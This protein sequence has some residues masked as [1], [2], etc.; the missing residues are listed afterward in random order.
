V[1]T[2]PV[3]LAAR[4]TY[5]EPVLSRRL[6]T[7]LAAAVCA[8]ALAGVAR[9]D[10]DPAS[11]VLYTQRIFL[12]FFGPKIAPARAT[13]LKDLVDKAW[14]K[15]YKIKVALIAAPAD[16]GGIPQLYGKPKTYV[17]FL[18]QELVF[19]FKGPLVVAMPNGLGFYQ[20]KKPVSKEYAIISKIPVGSGTDGLAQAATTAVAKLAGLKVSN[21]PPSPSPSKSSSGPWTIIGII[22]GGVVLLALMLVLGPMAVK[23]RRTAS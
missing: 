20:Y 22:A 7:L 12:P 1:L 15:G 4:R 2:F 8:A 13:V 5:P 18:G 16:L 6:A 21:G 14:K 19:L 17:K 23:R 11:D 10:A 9:A 3:T